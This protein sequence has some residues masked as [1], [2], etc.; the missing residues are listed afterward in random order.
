M[1]QPARHHSNTQLA[2]Y[3]ELGGESRPGFTATCDALF[4]FPRQPTEHL[5]QAAAQGG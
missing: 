1:P 5:A 2:H 4:A 3:P